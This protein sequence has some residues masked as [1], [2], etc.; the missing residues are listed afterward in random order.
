M[1]LNISWLLWRSH[2]ANTSPCLSLLLPREVQ[3]VITVIQRVRL[4]LPPALLMF[5]GRFNIRMLLA[6]AHCVCLYK[7]LRWGL[8]HILWVIPKVIPKHLLFFFSLLCTVH[9]VANT[10]VNDCS[11][12]TDAVLK[13]SRALHFVESN[14]KEKYRILVTQMASNIW[15]KIA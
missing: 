6:I 11:I 5:Y 3:Q 1:D 15:H 4:F 8:C 14:K 2:S 9:G 7:W 13:C 10:W 12:S